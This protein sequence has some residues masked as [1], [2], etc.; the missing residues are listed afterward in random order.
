[1]RG[2]V[3]RLGSM[4]GFR[5]LTSALAAAACAAGLAACG[6]DDEGGPIPADRGNALIATL[7][8][9]EAAVQAGDCDTAR[10]LVVSFAADVEALPLDED[11][12]L[13]NALVNASGNL[14]SLT[15]DPDQCTPTGTTGETGTLP[16]EPT[17]TTTTEPTTT[18]TTTEEPDEDEDNGGG[19]PEEPPGGGNGDPG[20]GNGNGSGGDDFSGGIGSDG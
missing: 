7:D 14:A 15:D 2:G 19:P 5:A 18:T 6:G 1:M 3:T 9:I 11:P 20:G 16:T 10:D 13:R 17:T 8:E 12:E 4:P